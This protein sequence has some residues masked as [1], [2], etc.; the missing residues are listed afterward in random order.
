MR[1]PIRRTRGASN[2]TSNASFTR[3]TVPSASTIITPSASDSMIVA[4]RRSTSR[5]R[6]SRFLCSVMSRMLTTIPPMGSSRWL[7]ATT[8]RSIGF[9][10]ARTVRISRETDSRRRATRSLKRART[11]ST[12]KESNSPN[13]SSPTTLLMS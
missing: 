7:A 6:C 8:S 13:A 10:S 1:R 11:G 12:L 4:W 9:P 3:T 2:I 5:T